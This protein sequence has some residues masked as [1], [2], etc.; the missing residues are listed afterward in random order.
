MKQQTLTKSSKRRKAFSFQQVTYKVLDINQ[1]HRL[2]IIERDNEKWAILEQRVLY[3]FWF[4]VTDIP[5]MDNRDNNQVYD[6]IHK[7]DISPY[8]IKDFTRH[9]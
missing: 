8:N 3:C 5:L 1:K 9:K 6:W 7:H 2:R 4:F